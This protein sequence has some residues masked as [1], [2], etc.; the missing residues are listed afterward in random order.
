MAP[1]QH[2]A[3]APVRAARRA[4]RI[5][6]RRLWHGLD[7]I[8]LGV[9]PRFVVPSR[10]D[11]KACEQL[12]E[13]Q[14]GR[15]VLAICDF[16][17]YPLSY[18]VV[19][20]LAAAERFRARRGARWLDVAFVGH[21]A[22]PSSDERRARLHRVALDSVRLFEAAGDVSLFTNRANFAGFLAGARRTHALFPPGF[23]PIGPDFTPDP[24]LPPLYG[25][26]H[27]AAEGP[28]AMV[29]RAPETA[30]RAARAWL[31][32]RI[33]GRTALTVTLRQSDYQPERNSD[34]AAWQA[35]VDAYRAS[36][37][38]FVVIPDHARLGAPCPLAGPH[39]VGCAE[40]ALDIAFRAA[41]YE[42]AHLNLLVNNGPAILCYLD[43]ATRYIVFKLTTGARS[44]RPE[45]L[46]W[47]HGLAP[48]DDLPFATPHQRLV[49]RPDTRDVLI[50]ET[51]A[52]LE[53]LA[54]RPLRDV[55]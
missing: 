38:A 21:A 10:S 27:L 31:D 51:G 35:L 43:A 50:G 55:G 16:A 48:G 30:R 18:D 26:R 44:T 49:W 42:A 45:D 52:M 32:A 2:I 47:L 24:H 36:P 41:L 9:P 13:G 15:R 53:R 25:L 5:A 37:Y 20:L 19:A 17:A 3:A 29:V 1:D 7:R 8:G 23:D 12:A 6:T 4:A 11:R 28:A 34:I 33:G 40:A 46:R 14:D 22:G 39:V 54:G